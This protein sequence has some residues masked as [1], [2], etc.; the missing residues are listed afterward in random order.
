MIK[1]RNGKIEIAYLGHSTNEI[2]FLNATRIDETSGAVNLVNA[3]AGQYVVVSASIANEFPIVTHWNQALNKG[4][5]G[6]EI[7]G[8]EKRHREM[9]G[10]DATRFY[11]NNPKSPFLWSPKNALFSTDNTAPNATLPD[12]EGSSV[13][14]IASLA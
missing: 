1:G 9:N 5:G 2:A 8:A 4:R 12:Y 3:R 14:I 11:D 10:S 13:R 7:G 6:R